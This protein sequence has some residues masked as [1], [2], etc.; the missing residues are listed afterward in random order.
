MLVKVALLGNAQVGK[1]SL[2]NRFVEKHF[3]S[4]ELP[5]Q[6]VNFSEKNVSVQNQT[7]E[8]T[9]SLWDI[10]GG[11]DYESMLPL[12]CNDASAMLFMFDASEPAT[13]DSIRDWHRKAR[14]RNKF[15]MPLLVATKYDI[16]VSSCSQEEQER[17]VAASQAFADAIG[18]P[19]IYCSSMVPINVTNIFKVL[20]I[21]LLGLERTVPQQLSADRPLL[22]YGKAPSSQPSRGGLMSSLF[23]R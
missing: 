6:G 11:P 15:A 16:L 9:L 18:A 14:E 3:D 2:M 4:T 13:L 21:Q 22:S 17:I 5:T 20:L 12:V 7:K 1:T 8:I 23:T 19:L 10:G